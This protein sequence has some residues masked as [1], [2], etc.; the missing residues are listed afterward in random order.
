MKKS[1]GLSDNRNS[2]VKT[3]K[4]L[5]ITG[6][7]FVLA[8]LSVIVYNRTMDHNACSFTDSVMNNIHH[9]IDSDKQLDETDD[10]FF[11]ADQ[12]VLQ[13]NDYILS[14]EIYFEYQN[15]YFTGYITIPELDLELPVMSDWSYDNL[16]ISP[17]RYSGSVLTDN[18]VI[19]AH[20][21]GNHF[22]RIGE[23]VPGDEV[24]Y[25]DPTGDSYRYEVSVTEVLKPE[26]IDRMIS[27]EYD[28]TLFTCTWAGTERVV[29]RCEKKET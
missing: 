9:Y 25:T 16:N 26:E 11:S 8:A 3:G 22:G 20:N 2:K 24:I 17:C 7:A 18:L 5:L 10:I 13:E 27:G 19:A 4:R 21:Y 29:V 15:Y 23:L 6:A 14:D 28:L 12:E 1:D